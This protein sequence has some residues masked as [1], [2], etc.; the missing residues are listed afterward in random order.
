MET[1]SDTVSSKHIAAID[2]GNSRIKILAD[3][4]KIVIG[5]KDSHSKA[6]TQVVK[7]AGGYKNIIISSVNESISKP[8]IS[9]FREVGINIVSTNEILDEIGIIDFSKVQGMGSDR[10]LGLVG[11]LQKDMLPLITIDCG[12]A[13]TVNLLDSKKVC[14]GG[15]IIPGLYTQARALNY[16]TEK[17]PEIKPHP[18][19]QS[20]GLNTEDAI[21]AGLFQS[22]AGAVNYI[23]KNMI[24]EHFP[25]EIPTI[26]L[27][28]GYSDCIKSRLEFSDGLNPEIIHDKELIL[29]G[30]MALGERVFPQ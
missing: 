23:L 3:W 21:N 17:L 25:T 4:K 22:V 7:I 1:Q 11:A 19:F 24:R 13:I 8:I 10:K 15:V 20:S 9:I 27:T 26:F 5:Y 16:Y 2:V 12:T 14:L 28:G 29:H 30:M 6:I 18:T